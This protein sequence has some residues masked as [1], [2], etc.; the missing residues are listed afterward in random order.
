MKQNTDR[1]TV[2]AVAEKAAAST[3]QPF[4]FI[5][6][7]TEV[8]PNGPRLSKLGETFE[9]DPADVLSDGGIPALPADLFAEIF[10]GVDADTMRQFEQVAA[11]ASMPPALEAALKTAGAKLQELRGGN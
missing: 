4:R 10:E 8:K 7:I 2:S 5:G 9:A 6:S 11:R 3:K 1:A